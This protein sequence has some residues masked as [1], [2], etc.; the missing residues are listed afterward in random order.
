MVAIEDQ[1]ETQ[2]GLRRQ[3]DLQ[4]CPVCGSQVD[5]DAYFCP[6]CRNYFCF[7]C[8]ARLLVADRQYQ[9]SNKIC[10]YYGKLICEVCDH[11]QSKDE[12]P[13][14]YLEPE[15]GYW[16][17]L[18]IGS[19]LLTALTWIASSFLLGF[20]VGL[21]AFAGGAYALERTGVNVFGREFEV[22]QPR[23]TACNTCICCEQPVREIRE[24]R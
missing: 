15:D 4:K 6:K 21:A 1:A 3:G 7:H 10:D 14:V 18:L 2:Q 12:P 11:E 17:L 19:L 23:S 24:R 20:V 5:S 22:S 8:R 13:A 16:P 9:C